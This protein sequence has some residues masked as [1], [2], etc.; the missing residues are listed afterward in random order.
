MIKSVASNLGLLSASAIMLAGC[1]LPFCPA[2]APVVDQSTP[3]QPVLS[4]PTVPLPPNAGHLDLPLE[5]VWKNLQ[6]NAK[7][8]AY[9][10]VSVRPF[11]YTVN[12]RLNLDPQRY[13]DCG[14]ITVPESALNQAG[15]F[16][17]AKS[18]QD[19]RLLIKQIPYQV[20]RR[21]SLE[22][23]ATLRLDPYGNRT[24]YWLDADYH[25]TREQNATSS[26]GPAIKARDSI[27]FRNGEEAVFKNAPTRC[28]SNEQLSTD[29]GQWLS[30][31]HSSDVPNARM[32]SAS[33]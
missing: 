22:V 30:G 10:I 17:G 5:M 18:A 29:V 16:P 28:K 27:H 20:K 7:L 21:M 14:M 23:Q 26:Q 1:A 19:Y 32:L 4:V 33:N 15:N 8:G 13:I 3:T 11:P 31:N 12:L 6:A 24:Y 2:P 25:V 9:R